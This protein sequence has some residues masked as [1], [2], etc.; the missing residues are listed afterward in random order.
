MPDITIHIKYETMRPLD[1]TNPADWCVLAVCITATAI[2]V[3]FLLAASK[4][5]NR[6]NIKIK[7]YNSIILMCIG[8]IIQI[9]AVF[10]SNGHLVSIKFFQMLMTLHCPV[11]DFWLP[12]VFG[13]SFWY[14]GLCQRM[15]SHVLIF[16]MGIMGG[17][18]NK[19]ARN[20]IKFVL[21]WTIYIFIV[22]TC[23]VLEITQGS[24]V[25]KKYHWCTANLYFKGAVIIWIS[26]CTILMWVMIIMLSKRKEKITTS[27]YETRNSLIVCTSFLIVL[28]CLNFMGILTFWWGR[29]IYTILIAS[30]YVFSIWCLVYKPI[31][32]YM[33]KS[34]AEIYEM[35]DIY[36][37]ISDNNVYTIRDES[38]M[39]YWLE[40]LFTKFATNNVNCCNY[41]GPIDIDEDYHPTADEVELIGKK[42]T[43]YKNKMDDY[44]YDLFFIRVQAAEWIIQDKFNNQNIEFPDEENNTFLKDA[45]VKESFVYNALAIVELY[46]AILHLKYCENEKMK[47]QMAQQILDRHFHIDILLL[48]QIKTDDLP[49]SVS[50]P[51][52]VRKS[53][54]IPLSSLNIIELYKQY[55]KDE[56]INYQRLYA[57]VMCIINRLWFV[58]FSTDRDTVNKVS[59]MFAKHGVQGALDEEGAIDYVMTEL[60]RKQHDYYK[61][62][63]EE[64]F[65]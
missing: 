21:I 52:D 34:R 44:Y 32:T 65:L 5:R 35:E 23:I 15:S 54:T 10:I 55:K 4:Y 59:S 64:D 33:F 18:K 61:T 3:G 28:T 22:L 42:T 41:I 14:I 30:M 29:S 11:F 27:Y 12:Y 37:E 26:S 8:S 36:R 60:K 53:H 56:M 58:E 20:T 24:H 39:L 63:S 2:L 43:E 6:P 19:I 49:C 7:N 13:F 51:I 25:D 17:T 50:I 40:E 62:H 31:Y 47:K 16:S 46:Y 38:I 1:R 48:N 9:W 45:V 57:L